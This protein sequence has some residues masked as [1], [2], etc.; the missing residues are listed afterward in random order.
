VSAA[1]YDQKYGP[2]ALYVYAWVEAPGTPCRRCKR[3]SLQRVSVIRHR[4]CGWSGR[5]CDLLHHIESCCGA[6]FTAPDD[7]RAAVVTFVCDACLVKWWGDLEM[8]WPDG[9]AQTPRQ[10]LRPQELKPSA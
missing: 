10:R 6:F 1:E 4:P 7:P 3:P 2:L 8:I 5:D 9:T